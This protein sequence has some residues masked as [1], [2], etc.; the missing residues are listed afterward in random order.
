MRVVCVV[1]CPSRSMPL[2]R[3][4]REETQYFPVQVLGQHENTRKKPFEIFAIEK[5]E[6]IF[7]DGGIQTGDFLH[8]KQ[9]PWCPCCC[10]LPGGSADWQSRVLDS[11]DLMRR[12]SW[13]ALDGL[14]TEE[15]SQ[16]ALKVERHR[17]WVVFLL[18]S[19]TYK[20]VELVIE[21]FFFERERLGIGNC[22]CGG[23]IFSKLVM[24]DL[25]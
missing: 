25:E 7:V 2:K 4:A 9:V 23:L 12:R 18:T 6:Q 22:N 20:R 10:L 11:T 13:A 21:H 1:A 19:K 14:D 17:R 16:G 3:W 5:G 15:T 8:G 24:F